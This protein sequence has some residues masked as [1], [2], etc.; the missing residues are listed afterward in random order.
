MDDHD[1]ELTVYF[2]GD[3]A[4]CR[5]VAAWLEGQPKYVPVHCVAA[6]AAGRGGC[7]LTLEALLAQVTVTA[8]DGAIY[9]GTNAWLI[10]LW[11]LRR[12]RAWSLRLAS[13]RLRPWA[14]RLFA[15]VTGFAKWTRAPSPVS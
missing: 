13:A 7:P 8:S 10:C 6:Q 14:E 15:V 11:A 3:C 4:F 12:Y 5:R 9:R 2:D 1:L